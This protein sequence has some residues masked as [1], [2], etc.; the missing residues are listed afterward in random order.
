MKP[1]QIE[2]LPDPLDLD[3]RLQISKNVHWKSQKGWLQKYT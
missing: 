1:S 2:I 3:A